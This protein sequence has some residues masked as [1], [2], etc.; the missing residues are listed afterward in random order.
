MKSDMLHTPDG[1]RDIYNGE[2]KRKL[3]IQ[4][5]LH[6]VFLRYGYQDIQTP[7]F[8]FFDI[9]SSEIGTTPSRDLYKFFD[10]EGNTLV[11]RPDFT[12]SVARSAAKYYMDEEAPIR[13]CYMGN[14]FVNYTDYKGRLKESTQCG[15]EFMGDGS[16]YADAELLA[17]AVE[18]LKSCGLYEFRISVGH[19]QYISSLLA[20][21]GVSDEDAAEIR[22]FLSNKNFFGVEE[23]ID[24]IPMPE[25]L[26]KLFAFLGSFNVDEEALQEAISYAADY[27]AIKD[28]LNRLLELQQCIKLYGI[29]KYVSIEP[30]IVSAY[31]YYTGMVF[32][33]YT[34][35]TGEAI[36]KGGR[37]DHLLNYFGKNAPAI[38]FGI[39]VD[40]LLSAMSYQN[41]PIDL[42]ENM[43][44]LVF[45]PSKSKEAIKKASL[46]RGQGMYVHTMVR[47][48]AK[49]RDYYD[50]Y[51]QSRN[52]SRVEFMDGE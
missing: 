35:G 52:I 21:A 33:G 12:P 11:L 16:V 20:A 1:V 50:Q 47:D 29:D 22:E 8:E 30:G 41:I 32:Y 28:S 18:A 2:C 48:V 25:S 4:E 34:F 49:S 39:V 27:P 24:H 31:T 38:G 37:Y 42:S 43:A 13:L 46:L 23:L 10:K 44:L 36:V 5:R 9:F 40:Q 17:M 7:T 14:T 45:A 51:A 15:V 6:Q 26:R 19:A 3:L